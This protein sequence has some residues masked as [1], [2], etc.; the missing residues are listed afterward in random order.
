MKAFRKL[1]SFF[2]ILIVG[3]GCQEKSTNDY[4]KTVL[5]NIEKIESASYFLTSEKW[6]HGDTV[7]N[8]IY[9]RFYKE[10]NNPADTTIGASMVVLDGKD[11]TKLIFCYDGEIRAT[12]NEEEKEIVIDD[13]TIMR[14]PFRM[15][16][17]PFFNK[18]KNIIQ[19]ILTTE[20]SIEV[21]SEDRGNDFYL[22]LTIK[23]DEQIE[24][25]GK[26]R[27]MPKSAYTQDNTSVYELWINKTTHLPYRVRREMANDIWVGICS[28]CTFNQLDIKDFNA[29]DYFP[30]NYKWVKYG[31]KR[32]PNIS[33]SQL[34]GE[35]APEWILKDKDEKEVSLS[36]FKSK[37]LL[38][39]FTGIGCGPCLASIPF[40]NELKN[41]Y[42]QEDVAVVGIE[43]WSRRAHSL[44]N[45]ANRHQ[46]NYPFLIANEEIV[47]QYHIKPAPVF[48]VLDEQ[49]VVRNVFS[50]YSTGTTDNEIIN[51]IEDLLP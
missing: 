27:R 8:R 33:P 38:L 15:I 29:S 2:L 42:G 25:F 13:F 12:V 9:N 1:F 39:E 41:K 32:M 23:E 18:T 11:T 49:R 24:F 10:Y 47:Q 37:V 20:D 43:F 30:V 19:Y 14:L 35:K 40:L 17:S 7:P 26:G 51:A 21:V 6:E 16:D 31:E 44:R 4:L 50:G 45:Y 28:D 36:D 46:I 48:F 22:K 5:A 34:I 3:V